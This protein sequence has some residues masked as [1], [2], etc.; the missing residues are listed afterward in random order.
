MK[1]NKIEKSSFK[2]KKEIELKEYNIIID[3]M[4][5]LNEQQNAIVGQLQTLEQDRI[6][7]FG[8]I[9][10]LEEMDKDKE[11]T[12]DTGAMLDEALEK[13]KI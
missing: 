3:K 13:S 9:Q 12:L 1:K 2:D 11:L 5:Y 6:R 10:I 7:I 8:R 4:K